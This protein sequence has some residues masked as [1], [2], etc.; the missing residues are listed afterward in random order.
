MLGYAPLHTTYHLSMKPM[1]ITNR[2]Y[3]GIEVLL[4]KLDSQENKTKMRFN[5]VGM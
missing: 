2:Y 4:F 3:S 1:G 5:D